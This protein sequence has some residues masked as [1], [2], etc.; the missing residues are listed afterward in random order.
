MSRYD[1]LV[2]LRQE[3]LKPYQRLRQ[4]SGLHFASHVIAVLEMEAWTA[5]RSTMYSFIW[6]MAAS[7]A[8][9]GLLN[10][11]PYKPPVKQDHHST[12]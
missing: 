12:L 9:L 7:D 3:H 8:I 6:P 2:I 11:F 4:L 10:Q 1:R 5:L